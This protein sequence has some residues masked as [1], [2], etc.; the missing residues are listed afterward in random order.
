MQEVLWCELT[1]MKPQLRK[2][3]LV[4]GLGAGG[5]IAFLLVCLV[6]GIGQPDLY[7]NRG[8]IG[9]WVAWLIS[10]AGWLLDSAAEHKLIRSDNVLVG[11]GVMFAYTAMVGAIVALVA[12]QL[13][14]LI[15]NAVLHKR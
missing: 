15:G 7:G 5:G 6:L 10:P 2:L 9:T 1:P 11:L 12:Y 8:M 14:R 13:R 3:V 4:A